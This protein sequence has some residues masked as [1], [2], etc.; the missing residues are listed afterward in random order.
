MEPAGI[1]GHQ[2]LH[3]QAGPVRRVIIY[4]QQLKPWDIRTAPWPYADKFFHHVIECGTIHF[5][6]ELEVF[7]NEAARL[8]Q[9][10][11]IFVFTLTTPGPESQTDANEGKYSF[12]T[13]DGVPVYSHNP[14]YI[15]ELLKDNGF[16]RRKALR[17]LLTR[18]PGLG[19]DVCT[20]VV[21]QKLA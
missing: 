18:G 12:E 15:A 2:A 13:M 16:E 4:N 3:H 1:T 11:G 5:L 6:A 14:K 10:Q 20:V 19:D 8:V 21:A 17:V 7:F 9:A